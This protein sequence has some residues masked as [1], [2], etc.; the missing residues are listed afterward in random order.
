MRGF[1]AGADDYVTKPFSLLEFLARIERLLRRVVSRAL[2]ER[3]ALDDRVVVDL[4]GRRVW[5]A[6]EPIELRPRA[7][8]LLMALLRRPNEAVSREA[9]LTDV[10]GY[11]AS[12]R[13]RTVDWHV[14]ELRRRIEAEPSRPQL[15]QTVRGFGYRLLVRGDARFT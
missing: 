4:S 15:V 12:A 3:V 11:E 5:I 10:W 13:T 8:D 9:L 7:F 6:G 14:A 2:P 1:R